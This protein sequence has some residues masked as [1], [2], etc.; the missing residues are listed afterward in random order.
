MMAV[1]EKDQM[2]VALVRAC[3]RDATRE[4]IESHEREGYEQGEGEREL[5][6]N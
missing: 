4:R 6:I 1:D 2:G 3:G 5:G